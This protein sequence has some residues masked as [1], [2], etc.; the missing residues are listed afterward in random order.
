MDNGFF[1]T[2]TLRF[3][4]KCEGQSRTVGTTTWRS[5]QLYY[6]LYMSPTLMRI[7]YDVMKSIDHRRRLEKWNL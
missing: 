5:Q 1:L 4:V 3:N 6:I 7:E 2:S